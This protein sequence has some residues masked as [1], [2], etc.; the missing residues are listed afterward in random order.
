MAM[1]WDIRSPRNGLLLEDGLWHTTEN[2]K[3]G[4]KSEGAKSLGSELPSVKAVVV[5]IL[6]ASILTQSAGT[7]QAYRM[8]PLS[9]A[10][11][12]T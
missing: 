10:A 3:Y 12:P 2:H 11:S 5:A 6:L 9:V 8:R 1:S 4:D 7:L